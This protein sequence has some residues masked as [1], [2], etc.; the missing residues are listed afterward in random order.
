LSYIYH[1]REVVVVMFGWIG[2]TEACLKAHDKMENSDFVIDPHAA[3][4]QLADIGIVS[5]AKEYCPN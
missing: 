1:D 2:I 5:D 4:F 3:I